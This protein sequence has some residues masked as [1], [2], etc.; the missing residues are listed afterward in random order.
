[1]KISV[2]MQSYLGD[3]PGSR[4]NPEYKF[5]RAVH[6]FLSQYYVDK[7][8]IIVSDGC[9]KTKALYESLYSHHP[10]IKFAYVAKKNE[11]KTYEVEE[12]DG[13][14][15]N[16]YRGTARRIGYS[17]AT[18]DI[19]TYM[20]SDDI[21]LP[22][23]LSDLYEAWKDKD[24]NVKWASNPLRY[25][26][27]NSIVVEDATGKSFEGT[28]NIDRNG[29]LYLNMLGYDISDPFYVNLMVNAGSH[30]TATYSISHRKNVKAEWQDSV[31]IKEGK[32]YISG[33]SEDTLFAMNL[34]KLDGPGFRQPSAAYVIC[35]YRKLWD[36]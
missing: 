3:Y 9:D 33:N 25:L 35:H 24:D 14:T 1:M 31:M 12:K 4:S 10:R 7:E 18:G 34:S 29:P 32:K 19:I 20:D 11:K 6:S 27:K 28:I 8:L 23:R 26:H 22:N 13:K 16:Y 5:T 36:V 15:I 2:I 21:M 30:S 17:I